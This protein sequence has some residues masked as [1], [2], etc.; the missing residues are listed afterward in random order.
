M[1]YLIAGWSFLKEYYDKVVL[2][3]VLSTLVV[4][5]LMQTLNLRK[6]IG[7]VNSLY[8]GATFKD[9]PVPELDLPFD[10]QISIP[11][12]RLWQPAHVPGL[13]LPDD[14]QLPVSVELREHLRKHGEGSLFD[15]S[16][17]MYSRNAP[18]LLVHYTTRYT[19][20]LGRSE[21][22]DL[23]VDELPEAMPRSAEE[24]MHPLISHVWLRGHRQGTLPIMFASIAVTSPMDK[25]QWDLQFDVLT[26]R[27]RRSYFARIGSEIPGSGGF[28]V[29]D[30]EHRTERLPNG[31]RK[32]LAQ[33][34]IARDDEQIVLPLKET[35]RY[36]PKEHLLVVLP[37]DGSAIRQFQVVLGDSFN[38]S[39]FQ[40]QHLRTE[41][42]RL[43]EA[44]NTQLTV[45]KVADRVQTAYDG[46]TFTVT[47]LTQEALRRHESR[48]QQ[49]EQLQRVQ[50]PRRY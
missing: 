18:E 12:E 50:Q 44:G 22:A 34:T 24:V 27:G 23:P 20:I 33:A 14:R 37:P 26:D 35:V 16:F 47:R 38:V 2:G 4:V 40:G 46:S 3:A 25:E 5:V 21:S 7:Q 36:G 29:T 42:Y 6:T 9:K 49:A 39:L 1:R 11:Q 15:P 19:P 43:V 48:R 41:S 30:V 8:S 45:E 32:V 10:V 17:Y 31:L 28:R 13:E